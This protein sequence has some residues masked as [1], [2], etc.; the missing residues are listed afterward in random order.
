MTKSNGV[1]KKE[2]I[3]DCKPIKKQKNKKIDNEFNI[4][5][6]NPNIFFNQYELIN[7]YNDIHDDFENNLNIFFRL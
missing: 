5:N 6:K 3:I 1:N 7:I 2:N 4:T